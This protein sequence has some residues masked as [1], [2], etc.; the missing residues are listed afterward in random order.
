MTMTRLIE[1]CNSNFEGSLFVRI[2]LGVLLLALGALMY[3]LN[4][5]SQKDAMVEYGY[6]KVARKTMRKRFQ[7]YTTAE[8]VTLTKLRK[9]AKRK[10]FMLGLYWILNIL[11]LGC[12]GLTIVGVFG[13]MITGAGW[14]LILLIF[15]PFDTFLMFWFIRFV[16]DI[17]FLPSERSRYFGKRH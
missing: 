7:Q 4:W 16:P 17:I 1:L 6:P 9:N 12:A 15:L 13:F 8:K 3:I 14:G 5:C 11:N 2:G 10:G